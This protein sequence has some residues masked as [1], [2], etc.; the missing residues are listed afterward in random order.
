MF[1]GE[2][3]GLY[4]FFW[5]VDIHLKKTVILKLPHLF[6]T[7]FHGLSLIKKEQSKI[8]A[9]KSIQAFS[10]SFTSSCKKTSLRV[11]P[12]KHITS[13]RVIH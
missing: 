7:F 6:L 5:L 2:F 1:P 3:Y 11:L 4:S 8:Q 10:Y 12:I 9:F 13:L